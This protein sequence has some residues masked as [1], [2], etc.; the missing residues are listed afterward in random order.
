MEEAQAKVVEEQV[1]GAETSEVVIEATPVE[2]KVVI[3]EMKPETEEQRIERINKIIAEKR[4]AEKKVKP[5]TAFE[6]LEKTKEEALTKLDFYER[7]VRSVARE[8]NEIKGYTE[9]T[10][11]K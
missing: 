7:V 1:Q 9:I 8:E 5:R 3:E 6:K 11:G 2:E 4:K 10:E